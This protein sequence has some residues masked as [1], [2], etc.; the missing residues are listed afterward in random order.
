MSN[1][2][3]ETAKFNALS[4]QWW[5][6]QGPLKTLHHLNPLRTQYI[7]E[8]LPLKGTRIL[9]VGCG[10]GLLSVALAERGAEVV[11]IDTAADLVAVARAKAVERGL[12]IEF[13]H[14]ELADLTQTDFDA[15]VC[16]ELLEHVPEPEVLL[17]QLCQR[18]KP[19][20]QLFVSTIN[21]T[22]MA[23][24]QAVVMAEYVLGLLPRQTHDYHRFIRPSELAAMLRTID[25]HVLALSGVGYNPING[26]AW[27]QD[28]LS[29][30]YIL[31][32]RYQPTMVS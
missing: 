5:D 25:C 26:H 11:A 29:V 31:S 13:I 3:R 2:D 21:R 9:D 27:L 30:N 32:T 18:L 14:G 12:A 16:M 10:G 22:P 1:D 4:A 8:H 28:D 6:P 23:Y 20:A 15:V 17:G 24:L 7:A 19:N